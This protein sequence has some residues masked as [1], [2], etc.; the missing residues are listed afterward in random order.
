MIF[1]SI[2][3]KLHTTALFSS[4][5]LSATNPP[6]SVAMYLKTKNN[7]IFYNVPEPS[8]PSWKADSDFYN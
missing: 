6:S 2:S 1:N 4:Q 3:W 7:I 5:Q 8:T